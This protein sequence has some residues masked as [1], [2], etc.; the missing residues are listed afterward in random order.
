MKLINNIHNSSAAQKL[1]DG[2]LEY[3]NVDDVEFAYHSDR[4]DNNPWIVID[5]QR[6]LIL[7]EVTIV[8]RPASYLIE[9]F[10]GIK[11]RNVSGICRQRSLF[12]DQCTS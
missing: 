6:T 12:L 7:S 10:G 4:R 9:S 8:I 1:T 5:L 11:V 3:S 2:I